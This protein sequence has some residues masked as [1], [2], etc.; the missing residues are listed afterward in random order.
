MMII[1]T[2]IFCAYFLSWSKL[3][4]RKALPVPIKEE[5]V[6]ISVPVRKLWEREKS[7]ASG[8]SQ[9]LMFMSSS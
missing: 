9:T 3:P 4:L 6:W 5:A 2:I 8:G 1:T 7:F